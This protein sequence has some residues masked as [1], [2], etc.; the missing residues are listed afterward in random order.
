MEHL[1]HLGHV[2][3][4]QAATLQSAWSLVDQALMMLSTTLRR[5][6]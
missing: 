5:W 4:A 6:M 2:Q 1:V 3:M